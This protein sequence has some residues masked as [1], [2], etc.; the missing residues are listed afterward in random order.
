M[1]SANHTRTYLARMRVILG[2]G[3][4]RAQPE[5]ALDNIILTIR[6][7]GRMDY[8]SIA[9]ESVGRMGYSNS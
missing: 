9:H 2:Q 5:L 7:R 1:T 8:E 3:V 6:P 4:L